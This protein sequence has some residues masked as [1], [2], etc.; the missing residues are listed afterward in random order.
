MREMAFHSQA[1]LLRHA[2]EPFWC[3]KENGGLGIHNHGAPLSSREKPVAHSCK[4]SHPAIAKQPP[5][6]LRDRL[7]FG[8][9]RD[10]FYAGYLADVQAGVVCTDASNLAKAV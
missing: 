9:I 2:D 1:R 7:V 3:G 8:N 5:E 4:A 10:F 6:H